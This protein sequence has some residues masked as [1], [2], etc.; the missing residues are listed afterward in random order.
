MPI[1]DCIEDRVLSE[2]HPDVSVILPFF[3]QGERIAEV[4]SSLVNSME[5][6]FELILID[7]ASRD[8]GSDIA[9]A[10]L[11]SKDATNLC[12]YR[13][14]RMRR[15]RFETAC[16]ALGFE[17]A[18]ADYFLEIQADMLVSDP[19]FDRR[20]VE[21]LQ[22]FPDVIAI[23]G[24]GAEKISPIYEEY[25]SGL[26]SV[27]T[28][29]RSL[30]RYLISQVLRQ[31]ANQIGLSRAVRLPL[32]NESDVR[33][34]R[35]SES[36]LPNYEDFLFSGRAGRLGNQISVPIGP[37]FPTHTVWLSQT[38]MRGPLAID[39]GKYRRVGGLNTASFFL[40]YDD[41]E[42]ALNSFVKFG[43]R[44]GFAP[45]NFDSPLEHGSSRKLRSL[46]DQIGIAFEMLRVRRKRK[47]TLLATEAAVSEL[48]AL[49]PEIRQLPT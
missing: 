38:I 34:Y 5:L 27:I 9:K 46:V 8:D 47:H 26:G 37:D 10:F 48:A 35:D 11:R 30:G 13:I 14:F 20:L 33:D 42:F 44:T 19:G 25:E 3:N 2:C 28:P 43:F 24:R 4:L 31:I 41:H 12:R 40:G 49:K 18:T 6:E 1:A 17:L 36:I 15:S 22:V 39:A 21:M 16:D 32:S 45:V 23:S 7:D 29:G